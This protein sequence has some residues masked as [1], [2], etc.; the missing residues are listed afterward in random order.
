MKLL[1]LFFARMIGIKALVCLAFCGAIG[2]TFLF[3]A[4]ALPVYQ[5]NWNPFS[6]IVFYV[7]APLPLALAKRAISNGASNSALDV[8]IF[9]MACF[10]VSAFG[11]PLVLAH[12]G[13]IMWGA[14]GLVL[15]GNVVIF[16][17]MF[18]YFVMFAN[19]D[20]DYSMW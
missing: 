19:D 10:M 1:N 8:G 6:V 4:C 18:A 15:A 2:M 14:A 13:V 11:L 20:V 9:L 12:A 7:V 16:M 3:L 5:N 17:T